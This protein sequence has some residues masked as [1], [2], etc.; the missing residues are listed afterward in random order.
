MEPPVPTP[1]EG[2][3]GHGLRT[4][5]V[6]PWSESFTLFLSGRRTR[7]TRLGSLGEV[8][9]GRGTV[10]TGVRGREDGRPIVEP[11]ISSLKNPTSLTRQVSLTGSEMTPVR[12]LQ[13]YFHCR[14]VCEFSCRGSRGSRGAGVK[15]H[16]LSARPGVETVESLSTASVISVTTPTWVQH[17]FRTAK[18]H[19]TDFREGRK[20]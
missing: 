3:E 20:R 16:S 13:P 17:A 1:S 2:G 11:M 12:T 14:R 18:T 10:T 15:G 6:N 4:P 9:W 19:S 8:L 7:D 5:G